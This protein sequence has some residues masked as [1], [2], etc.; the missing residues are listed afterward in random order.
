MA[1]VRAMASATSTRD[2][3]EI[4][5]ECSRVGQTSALAVVST[6][7]TKVVT[8]IEA[9]GRV[10]VEAYRRPS[11]ASNEWELLHEGFSF[12]AEPVNEQGDFPEMCPVCKKEKQSG[13]CP[14]CH[15]P[16]Y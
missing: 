1:R 5:T 9:D 7:L 8:Q 11:R 4:T 15:G 16:D 13:P 14:Y 6:H 3:N 12:P 2:R 10:T